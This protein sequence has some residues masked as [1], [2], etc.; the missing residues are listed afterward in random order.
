MRQ[1]LRK[2]LQKQKG[3]FVLG[4]T[5]VIGSGK[6]VLCRF[7]MKKHGFFWI[8]TDK[9]VHELYQKGCLGYK[10][11]K[12]VFGKEYVN[13]KEVDRGKLRGFVLKNSKKLS[14]LNELIHPLVSR[15]V[16]K[17]I[18]QIKR[19]NKTKKLIKI[20]L[21]AVYFD[22]GNLGKFVDRMIVIGA[23]EEIILKR[24]KKRRMPIYQFKKLIFFQ[25]KIISDNQQ[26][27]NN[28][29]SLQYL[30]KNFQTYF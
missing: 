18:V 28:N 6:S 26:I 13:Q 30:Y 22:K 29:K 4:V 24:I 25:R 3:V 2:R 17:K 20:C 23:D 21:E 10:K 7:L 1:F 8:E 27:I 16:Y 15:E 5:G 11:I 14:V 9:I 12:E 19:T